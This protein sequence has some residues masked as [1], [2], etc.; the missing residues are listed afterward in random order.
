MTMSDSD[1][2]VCVYVCVLIGTIV[3]LEVFLNN[4][5]FYRVRLVNTAD[6]RRESAELPETCFA[7]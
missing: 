6:L 4:C 5:C 3:S 7:M 2:C 1:V